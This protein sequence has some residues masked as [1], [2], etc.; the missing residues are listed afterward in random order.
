MAAPA[1]RAQDRPDVGRSEAGEEQLEGLAR[2]RARS[3]SRPEGKR[4]A[5]ALGDSF[6]F[7]VGVDDGERYTDLLNARCRGW[8][9]VN[10]GVPGYGIDQ[11]LR[12]LEVEAFR[13]EPELVLLTVSLGTD[14]EDIRHDLL[15]SQPKPYYTFDGNLLELIP[16][17]ETLVHRL[18]NLSY[19]AEFVYR[20]LVDADRQSNLAPEWVDADP[21]P[22]FERIVHRIA[23]VTSEHGARLLVVLVYDPE[24]EAGGLSTR[25]EKLRLFFS[26]AGIETLDTYELFHNKGGLYRKGGDVHWNARGHELVA[27][28]LCTRALERSPPP[29]AK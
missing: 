9:V 22:L 15:Y 24:Q 10:L 18:R 28:M 25:D 27:Q 3:Y 23:E 1:Q 26:E 2:R 14:P 19:L 20:G 6:T 8:E 13:Y 17:Q 29:T 21:V 7:G 4:R 16:P 5:V 11:E 12:L